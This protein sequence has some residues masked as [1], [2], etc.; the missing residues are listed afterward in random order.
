MQETIAR[1][2][3]AGLPHRPTDIDLE[4]LIQYGF[5]TALEK[6]IVEQG[7]LSNFDW[8]NSNKG[9]IGKYLSENQISREIANALYHAFNG[10]HHAWHLA[11]YLNQFFIHNTFVNYAV[12]TGSKTG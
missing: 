9:L 6:A 5:Y 1:A 2:V 8:A 7:L 10:E 3:R 4:T 11:E 12:E